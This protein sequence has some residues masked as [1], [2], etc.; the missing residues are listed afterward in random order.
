MLVCGPAPDSLCE[1]WAL[2][3]PCSCLVSALVP[4]TEL[5]THLLMVERGSG[6]SFVLVVL[7]LVPDK[8]SKSQGYLVQF[9]NSSESPV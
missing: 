1:P 4:E 3:E 9:P 6:V 5:L 2:G 7:M 8:F